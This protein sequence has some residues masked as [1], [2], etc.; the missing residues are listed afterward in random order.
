METYWK[1]VAAVGTAAS[2]IAIGVGVATWSLDVRSRL[3]ELE[4]RVNLVVSTPVVARKDIGSYSDY[5]RSQKGSITE[6]YLG[7][8]DGWGVVPNP[9]VATCIDLIQ[10]TATAR[11]KDNYPIGQA[12]E[13]LAR[14]Y[15]C[16]GLLK[17][18]SGKP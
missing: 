8:D 1:I 2:L 5:P 14:T 10:R 18:I 13:G 15:D 6:G 3:T 11:E 4:N 9:L 7:K 16:P 12:L 17:G